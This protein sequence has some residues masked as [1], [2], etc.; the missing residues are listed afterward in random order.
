[1]TLANLIIYDRIANKI[2]LKSITQRLSEEKKNKRVKLLSYGNQ[3][4]I[5]NFLGLDVDIGANVAEFIYNLS[6][7]L[8]PY[9]KIN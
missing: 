4:I 8:V 2:R 3:Q 5:N 6:F 7:C 9:L 1:M